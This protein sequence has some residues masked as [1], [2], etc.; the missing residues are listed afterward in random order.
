MGIE[1]SEVDGHNIENLLSTFEKC[2]K[3]NKFKCILAKTIK[4]KGSSVMENKK[5]WHYWNPMNDEEI[6][7][8]RKELS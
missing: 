5:Q 8:T 6:K 1:T 3:I 2:Q 4:G 7:V